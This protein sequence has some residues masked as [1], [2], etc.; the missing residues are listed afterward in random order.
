MSDKSDADE[1]V[2]EALDKIRE[3][4]GD[5]LNPASES[6][7][8]AL[9]RIC[10]FLGSNPKHHSESVIEALNCIRIV[11]KYGGGKPKPGGSMT[12][13]LDRNGGIENV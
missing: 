2:V 1:S 13:A 4:I 6:V 3:A 10:V 9:D 5:E 8:E 12:Y 7:V 11:I